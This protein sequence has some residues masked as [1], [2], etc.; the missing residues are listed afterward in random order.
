M[1]LQKQLARLAAP[2]DKRLSISISIR[3]STRDR[4]AAVLAQVQA[5]NPD[6]RISH[7]IDQLL[8]EK[9]DDLNIHL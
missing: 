3:E 5:Q 9:L 6:K 2:E 8:A 4:V 1:S 7:I